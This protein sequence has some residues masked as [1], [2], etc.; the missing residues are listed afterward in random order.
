MRIG[1]IATIRTWMPLA[2]RWTISDPHP[3]ANELASRLKV[4]PLV[5]QIL[6]NRGV[7]ELQDCQDF[8]RPS[9]K[10]LHDPVLLANLPRASERIAKAIR[11]G[12]KIVIYGDYD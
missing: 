9:L 4:S 5:S 6:L 2:K 12:Q 1:R 10:C 7:S 8:L 3:L 11:D